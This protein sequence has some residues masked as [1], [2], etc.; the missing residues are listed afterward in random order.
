MLKSPMKGVIFGAVLVATLT[1]CGTHPKDPFLNRNDRPEEL[2][3]NDGSYGDPQKAFRDE[4][5]RYVVKKG[6]TLWGISK[7]FLVQPWHWKTLWYNNPQV[8]NPHLIYPGDV[9]SIVR[10]G[11]Q[12][13]ITISEAS[14]YHGHNT[15]RR[16]KDGRAIYKYTPNGSRV[17]NLNDG[18]ITISHK[19]LAPFI[20]KTELLEAQAVKDQ[21]LPTVFGDAGDYLTLSEQRTIFTQANRLPPQVKEFNIY[22][23]GNPIQTYGVKVEQIN[24]QT[25]ETIVKGPVDAFQMNYVGSA[26]L[27]EVDITR[28]LGKLNLDVAANPINEGD[29]LLPKSPDE[30]NS[31]VYF[32]REPS[33]QCSRGYMISSFNVHSVMLK[34]FDSVVTS[35]GRDNDAKVGDIWKI[36]RPGTPRV[37]NGETVYLPPKDIGFLMIIK[38][39]DK[40]SVGMILDSTQNIDLTDWLVRP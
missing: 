27:A 3:L 18:P 14:G 30:D 6:D 4:N 15:G 13:R 40:Y 25:R 23:V 26:T 38:V 16:T 12:R 21:M 9:L 35:F 17:Y 33:K 5:L 29:I 34:E 39:Y 1:A 10:V 24:N 32:P 20:L 28:N 31:S 22:N 19:T 2:C 7:R 36:A 37:I 8:R 11:G